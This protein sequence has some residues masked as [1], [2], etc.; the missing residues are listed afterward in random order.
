MALLNILN[1]QK[2]R[3]HLVAHDHFDLFSLG[4]W[5]A[6]KKRIDLQPKCR[7]R[8][9]IVDDQVAGWCGIQPDEDK[10][11]L[12]IVIDES[13]WGIGLTIFKQLMLWAKELKHDRV[14][15]H[16]LATRK[17]YKFLERMAI[18][19]LPTRMMGHD[20]VTYVFVVE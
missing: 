18:K 2:V 15:I 12:A 20:F 7:V 6:E 19:K 3:T 10:Y 4:E 9:V 17:S 1:K 11:E 5:I 8:A 14:L 13:F 16:L